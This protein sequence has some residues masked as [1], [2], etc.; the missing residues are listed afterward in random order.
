[1]HHKVWPM[2]CPG[3]EMSC[4]VAVTGKLQCEVIHSRCV[5]HWLIQKKLRKPVLRKLCTA[6]VLRRLRT[7]M[8]S[9]SSVPMRS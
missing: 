9:S 3:V 8:C 7:V 4:A 1:M 5:P 6:V 2:R